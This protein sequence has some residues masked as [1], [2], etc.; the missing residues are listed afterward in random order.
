LRSVAKLIKADEEIINKLSIPDKLLTLSLPVRMDNVRSELLL[1][2]D[3]N[4]IIQE[5]HTKG[6]SGIII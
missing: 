1:P 5:D 4:I 2:I 3:L 6:G